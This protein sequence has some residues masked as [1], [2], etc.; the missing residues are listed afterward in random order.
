MPSIA[1]GFVQ[2][3]TRYYSPTRCAMR[4]TESAEGALMCGEGRL[5]GW[6]PPGKDR[7]PLP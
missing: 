5:A 1:E 2:H 7:Q 4:C 3:Q 6:A